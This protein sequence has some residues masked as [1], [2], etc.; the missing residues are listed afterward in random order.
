MRCCG[1]GAQRRDGPGAVPD[2]GGGD[3]PDGDPPPCAFTITGPTFIGVLGS[4]TFSV[5][6]DPDAAAIASVE[7][8]LSTG[9]PLL[10]PGASTMLPATQDMIAL[11]AL[12]SP[13]VISITATVTTTDGQ[14]CSRGHSIT[15]GTIMLKSVTFGGQRHQITQDTGVVYPSTQHWL[16]DDLDGDVADAG[17]RRIPIAYTRGATVEITDIRFAIEPAGADLGD[18]LLK[19]VGPDGQAF[20]GMAA[21]LGGEI[22]VSGPLVASQ[23][24]PDRVLFYNPY[25]IHWSIATDAAGEVFEP[26][27]MSDNRVYVTLNDPQAS[28]LFETVIDIAVRNADGLFDIES[29][30]AAVYSD[31]TDRSVARKAL[32]GLNVPDGAVMQ[33]W[34]DTGSQLLGAIEGQCQPMATM[35]DPNAPTNPPGIENVGTCTAWAE[36]LANALAAHSVPNVTRLVVDSVYPLAGFHNVGKGATLLVHNWQFSQPGTLAPYCSEYHFIGPYDLRTAPAL[37]VFNEA[38]DLFGSPGQG[39]VGDPPAEFNLHWIIGRGGAIVGG[40]WTGVALYDPSYGTGPFSS[41]IAWE[42]ASC[43]GHALGCFLPLDAYLPT[44]LMNANQGFVR[45]SRTDDPELIET[46]VTPLP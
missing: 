10:D 13:G 32:D 3:D 23:P 18:I 8:T 15:V 27:G 36:L 14:T 30:V 28:P 37:T 17:D 9:G 42:A 24:L 19:G 34:A 40:Q 43:A 44:E 35:I 7:W 25:S 1:D 4:A 46:Q 33:Y 29:V 41:H 20:E 2:D 38:I 22:V 16:D 5:A 6:P 21:V 12:D 26:V 39:G 45:G 31:F 11:T